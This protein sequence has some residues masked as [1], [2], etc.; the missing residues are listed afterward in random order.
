MEEIVDYSGVCLL[1]TK[2][3]ELEMCKRFYIN[4]LNYLDDNYNKNYSI[5][6]TGL[7]YK[8]KGPL[9]P[10]KFNLGRIAFILCLKNDKFNNN[11]QKRNNKDKLIEYC[12]SNLFTDYDEN[13]IDGT[14]I[15]Y[16]YSIEEIRTKYRNPSAHTNEIK[17]TDA[18][19]CFD[20][21]LDVEKL[22]KKMLDSFDY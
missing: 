6:P 17:R 13:K 20:L 14:L 18:K 10:E 7:L 1:V 22:L 19:D 11:Q 2:T 9:K 8:N 3:L 4:F 21:V 12:K 5:Y 16:A 15:D